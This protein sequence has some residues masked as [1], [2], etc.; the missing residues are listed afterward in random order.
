M[1]IFM[2]ST[3]FFYNVH[4]ENMFTIDIEDGREAPLKP[5]ILLRDFISVNAKMAMPIFTTELLKPLSD[6]LC[7]RFFRFKLLNSDFVMY[8]CASHLLRETTFKNNQCSK[9]SV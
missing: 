6:E 1:I 2:K 9:F 5:S 4:K 7:G 8:V 3:N